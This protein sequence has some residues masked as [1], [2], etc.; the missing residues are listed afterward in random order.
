MPI[1]PWLVAPGL[2]LLLIV[3]L[4]AA[5]L[6]F[7]SRGA[8]AGPEPEPERL[9]VAAP[10]PEPPAG[11]P[12]DPPADR[13]RVEKRDVSP[14][15]LPPGP[16][17]MEPLVPT[18]KPE[19]APGPGLAAK[20]PDRAPS[21]GRIEVKLPKLSEALRMASPGEAAPKE[22]PRASPEREAQYDA[23]VQR[24]IL[25]DIGRLAGPKAAVDLEALG[26][27]AIRALVRGL[28]RSATLDASCPVVSISDKLGRLLATCNDPE[29]LA[30]VRDGIGKGVGPTL[31]HAYLT[32]VK[33]ACAERLKKLKDQ[34]KPRVPQLVAALKSKDAEARRKAANTLGLAGAEAKAAVP[35]LA[36]ALKD[37]DP[38]ARGYAAS[39][40]AAIGA[41]AAPALLKAADAGPDR[42]VRDLAGLA[43]E[44]IDPDFRAALPALR[45]APAAA[46]TAGAAKSTKEPCYRT[47]AE[48]VAAAGEPG[49]PAKQALRELALRRGE[50]ALTA[51]VLAAASGDRELRELGR[52]L[53]LKYLSNRPDDKAEEEAARRL[54][55]AR[56]VLDGGA[57][58]K[59]KDGLRALIKSHPRT[60]AAEDARRLLA[61][62]Q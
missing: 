60:R 3:G 20:A 19:P 47:V 2:M 42:E 11:A 30:E 52:D 49:D 4:T 38:E 53:L 41:P 24:F 62:A 5:G 51:L 40:L 46:T 37:S 18:R 33:Q 25:Y 50:E 7:V 8:K 35:A 17:S 12:A 57:G 58:G 59:A 9:S 14:D 29:L 45:Q 43:L 61:E 10:Q 23:V 22:V 13:G 55:L 15:V 28:N 6:L 21:F 54:K 48:L 27:D 31:H 44:A 39:A 36:E 34:L 16:L 32:A 56:Q 26:P 1:W